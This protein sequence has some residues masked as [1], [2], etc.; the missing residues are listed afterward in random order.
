ME[1][2]EINKFTRYSSINN[3]EKREVLLLIGHKCVW[4]KCRF[5]DYHLDSSD[6]DS[7]NF[8]IN[9]V[10]IDKVTGQFGI[11]E[12]SNSGS[13]MELDPMTVQ[14][15]KNVCLSKK[16]QKLIVESHWIYR[17]K[18]ESFKKMFKEIGVSLV[19][20]IGVE[21]FDFLFRECYLSKGIDEPNPEKIAKYFDRVCL[22]FG[23]PGQTV[24]SMLIDIETSL[25]YF[26]RTYVNIMTPN[27]SYIKPDARVI[28]EFQE[29]VYPI[30]CDNERVDILLIN[31]DFGIGG[32]IVEQ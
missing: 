18:I 10:A 32:P 14:Y 13:F 16:I 31:T 7:K 26:D 5:C 19:V 12:I 28:R 25:K 21:T 29:K 24:E 1:S 11:L 30:F 9:K 4:H 27:S 17:H 8:S 15:I 23:I 6:N 20:K 22:L 3:K 2:S